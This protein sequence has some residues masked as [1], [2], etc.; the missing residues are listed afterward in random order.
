MAQPHSGRKLGFHTVTE[1]L[2]RKRVPDDLMVESLNRANKQLRY[3]WEKDLEQVERPREASDPEERLA[4]QL[5][6]QEPRSTEEAR[7][8]Q[9]DLFERLRE[10]RFLIYPYQVLSPLPSSMS[11]R[12]ETIPWSGDPCNW[13][14]MLVGQGKCAPSRPPPLLQQRHVHAKCGGTGDEQKLEIWH[15]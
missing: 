5:L 4:E 1:Q 8:Q 10:F 3:Q 15:F 6:E 12:P 7:M 13:D 9:K 11:C 2:K 14:W